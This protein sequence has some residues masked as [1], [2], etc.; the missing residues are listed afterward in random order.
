MKTLPKADKSSPY[1]D[2]SRYWKFIGEDFSANNLNKVRFWVGC[3]VILS[4]NNPVKI[5]GRLITACGG[6]R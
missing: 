2:I 6:R 3:C 5:T 4:K 1:T